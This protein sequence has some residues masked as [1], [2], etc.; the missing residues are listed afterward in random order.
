[1]KTAIARE[2]Y[3]QAVVAWSAG[4]VSAAEFLTL[5]FGQ[6]PEFFRDG[7]ELRALW[8]LPEPAAHAPEAGGGNGR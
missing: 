8:S 2:H 4:W 3:K 5:L 1:M 6:L 7:D